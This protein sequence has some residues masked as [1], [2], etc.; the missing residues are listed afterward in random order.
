MDTNAAGATVRVVLPDLP[1]T[2]AAI[3]V[4][5]VVR[6]VAVPDAVIEATF[7]LDVDHDAVAVRF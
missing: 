4:V 6:A 7:G 5:P 2:A 1:E 3:T